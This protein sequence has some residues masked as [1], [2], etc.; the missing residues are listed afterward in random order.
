MR[1]VVANAT[2]LLE[3]L[4]VNALLHQQARPGDARLSG[5]GEDPRD[6]ALHR[7]V[8]LGVVEHDVRRFAAELHARAL[9]AAGGRFVDLL[10]RRIGTGERHLRD[11][12][13]LDKRRADLRAEAGDDV[14]DAGREPGLFDELD[15][16]RA[17]KRT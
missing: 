16:R 5:G 8:D 14:D 9:Q 13:M 6:H 11:E 3:K 4:I 12:R 17:P 2:Q 1:A 15:E 7:V 10:S